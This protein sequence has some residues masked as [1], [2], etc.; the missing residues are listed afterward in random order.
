MK[1]QGIVEDKSA[2]SI[3]F[4]AQI[5]FAGGTASGVLPKFVKRLHKA[6]ADKELL[7]GVAEQLTRSMQMKPMNRQTDI[8]QSKRVRAWLRN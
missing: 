5:E 4:G 7:A 2:S 6:K 1:G 3:P 8:D